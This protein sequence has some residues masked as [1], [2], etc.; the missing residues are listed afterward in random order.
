[1]LAAWEIKLP[2]VTAGPDFPIIQYA[3]DTL[4]IMQADLVQVLALKEVL[5]KYSE[6]TGLHINYHK[7]SM[8]AINVEDSVVQQLA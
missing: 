3:D 6:S 5:K 1:L 4:L 8:M 7:S 2:I